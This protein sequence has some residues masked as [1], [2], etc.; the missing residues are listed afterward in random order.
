MIKGNFKKLNR[1][2]GIVFF[3]L[4][5]VM[6]TLAQGNMEEDQLASM[7][8]DGEQGMIYGTIAGPKS[9]NTFIW[10]ATGCLIGIILVVLS[11]FVPL[12]ETAPVILPGK[13]HEYVLFYRNVSEHTAKKKKDLFAMIG[14][15][16]QA[17]YYI[18]V[19]WDWF[20]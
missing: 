5:I 11:Y 19:L 20:S 9:A 4:L 12:N 1:L 7:L 15:G 3:V 17:V 14:F 8:T 18:Y 10:L 13:S 16:L 6:T 2:I